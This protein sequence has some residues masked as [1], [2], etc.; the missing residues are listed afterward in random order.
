MKVYVVIYEYYECLEI[1]GVFTDENEAEK[2]VA[3]CPNHY[4]RES[5]LD[6]K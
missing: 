1:L 3:G 4:I 6:P 2:L 5:T